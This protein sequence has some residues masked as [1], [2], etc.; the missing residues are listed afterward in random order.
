MTGPTGQL[1]VWF[2]DHPFSPHAGQI[3]AWWNSFADLASG[4]T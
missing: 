2:D 1:A 3:N 4:R